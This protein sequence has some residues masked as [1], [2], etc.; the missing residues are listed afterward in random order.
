MIL[1]PKPNAEQLKC[2]KFRWTG[3]PVNMANGM[4]KTF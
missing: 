3:F 2:D 1:N 4:A